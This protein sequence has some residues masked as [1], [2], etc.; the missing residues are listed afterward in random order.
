MPLI[1]GSSCTETSAEDHDDCSSKKDASSTDR[2]TERHTNEITDTHEE[3]R[4]SHE[5]SDVSVV[6]ANGDVGRNVEA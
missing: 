6:L 2:D 4:I 3:G 5:V 1:G